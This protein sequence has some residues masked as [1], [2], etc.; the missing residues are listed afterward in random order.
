MRS[1]SKFAIGIV[2]YLSGCGSPEAPTDATVADVESS[3]AASAVATDL[4]ADEAG[5]AAVD[6]TVEEAVSTDAAAAVE[7]TSEPIEAREM[8]PPPPSPGG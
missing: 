6:A 4:D 7:M 5:A 2:L 8:P 3:D 1:V